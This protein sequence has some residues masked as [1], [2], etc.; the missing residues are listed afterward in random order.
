MAKGQE[1]TGGDPPPP[2]W[3]VEVVHYLTYS[4][5]APLCLGLLLLVAAAHVPLLAKQLNAA[6]LLYWSK[7]V[8]VAAVFV[9]AVILALVLTA[10][11]KPGRPLI[12]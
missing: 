1:D 3:R 11:H 12:Y 10:P 4:V 2:N 5:L 8:V 7:G 6:S 9:A